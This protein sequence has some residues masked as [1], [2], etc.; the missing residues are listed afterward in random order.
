MARLQRFAEH[1]QPI[2]KG[3]GQVPV[4]ATPKASNDKL[5]LLRHKALL[6]RHRTREYTYIPTKGKPLPTGRIIFSTLEVI[7]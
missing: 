3:S 7:P 6:I 5:L 1:F 4:K 2:G